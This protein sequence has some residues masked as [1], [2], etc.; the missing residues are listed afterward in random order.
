MDPDGSGPQTIGKI[1]CTIPYYDCII[2]EPD[3]PSYIKQY[4]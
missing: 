4:E 3:R 1:N 2:I